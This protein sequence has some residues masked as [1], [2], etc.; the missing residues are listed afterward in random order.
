MRRR[1][2]KHSE[3]EDIAK[4]YDTFWQYPVITEYTFYQQN[5]NNLNYLGFPWA[6]MIDS[7]RNFNLSKLKNNR[8][9][10][11][12]CQH[13]F[14]RKLIGLFKNL[15]INVVYTPHKV[16]G[17]DYINEIEIKSCPLY[18]VNVEDEE[19]NEIFRDVDFLQIKRKYLYSF[20]GG[21]NSC[22][23]SDIRLNLFQLKLD[24]EVLIENTNGWHFENTIYGGQQSKEKKYK[25]EVKKINYY[26]QLLLNSRFSL[27]PSGSGPNSIRFWESLAVGSIPVLISDKL[28]LPTT[29]K[30]LPR[31]D[32]TIVM[33]KESD[34]KNINSVLKTI[35]PEEE[36]SRRNN[37][38]EIYS[39]FRNNY[40]EK[41]SE[42]F[43]DII[44]YC[45][46]SY[47]GGDFGGVARF[48][49][50]LSK[51]FPQKKF[52][53]GVEQKNLLLK[54]LEKCTNPLIIT[55]NHLSCD[56]P[57]KYKIFLV[58][59]G[60]ARTT[61][62][63]NPDW[64]EPWRSLCVNGQNKMLEYRDVKTTK[65][66]SIS[67]ACSDDFAKFYGEKYTK[68]NR[69]EIP[70][71]SELD[72][73][74]FKKS[75]NSK[76]VILGNWNHVKKGKNLLPRLKDQLKNYEFKQLS[77]HPNN[78]DFND[79][80]KRKQDIYLNTDI[81]LQI[82]N[83][84]GN[85]Y[86]TNDALICGLVVVA[87]DVGLFYKDVP[88]DCFVR[89]DWRKNGDVKYVKERLEYAWKNKEKLS[90][91]AR[92]WYME[93]ARFIDWERKIKNEMSSF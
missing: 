56:I 20:A 52:F 17:E 83:S 11:T 31:W 67:K 51:I 78:R 3:D 74:R 71:P 48:D 32:K 34:Y 64:G 68:F 18:A 61:A 53:K 19:R 29:P 39:Y 40:R 21:Y 88:D 63:R 15:N 66:I 58:H 46:G 79:F 85:S 35:G 43:T 2:V 42:E 14:F 82:S 75:F 76:P 8:K 89:L 45:C 49:Y 55:D 50:Q 10:Y 7:K 86:A 9:K 33:I 90:N 81:F 37:C 1:I 57:N 6:T 73:S 93:N 4:R 16:I 91:N 87:S 80:N 84:E 44:S 27:C 24:D 62:D 70:N 41:V 36:M 38:I 60:C 5:K 22:Y 77:V 28:D 13:I 92:K 26:N 12:C 54:Y 72:E 59:H 65:I 23:M 30:N 25:K 47:E 69:I